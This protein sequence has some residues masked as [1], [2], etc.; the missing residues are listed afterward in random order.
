MGFISRYHEDE[1]RFFQFNRIYVVETLLEPDTRTGKNLFHDMLKP[2]CYRHPWLE[3]SYHHVATKKRLFELLAEIK[4]DALDGIIFPWIHIEGHGNLKGLSVGRGADK[5]IVKW[6][7]LGVELRKIN[8]A[9]KNNLMLVAATCHG[10]NLFKGIRVADR[11]PFFGFIAPIKEVT[12]QEVEEGFNTFYQRILNS[13]QFDEAMLDLCG[14][15]NG[16]KPCF[17]FLV[18]EV[19]FHHVGEKLLAEDRDPVERTRRLL[20]TAQMKQVQATLGLSFDE[21]VARTRGVLDN[22]EQLIQGW[23]QQFIMKDLGSDN[24]RGTE[25]KGDRQSQH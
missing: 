24:E 16:G 2:N 8:V 13:D 6:E 22:R 4:R 7:D 5:T 10:S 20:E 25:P 14:A 1:Q 12:E 11:A 21:L 19:A 15:R 3:A 17:T 18:A 23:F 9:T